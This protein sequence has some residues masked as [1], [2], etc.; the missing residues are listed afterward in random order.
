MTTSAAPRP[1]E[2]LG[3]DVS[4]LPGVLILARHAAVLGALQSLA[5]AR[6]TLGPEPELQSPYNM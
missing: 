3:R 1:A 4:I 5:L 6:G 2:A